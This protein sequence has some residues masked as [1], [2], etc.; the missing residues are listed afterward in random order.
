MPS[1]AGTAGAIAYV[2]L[3][4]R[5]DNVG[6][7][8]YL[9]ESLG[10]EL[11]M[12]EADAYRTR[13][14][15]QPR[16][17][18]GTPYGDRAALL[19]W[20]LEQERSGCDRY[21][22]SLDQLLSGGL[23]N[24]RSMARS[25]PIALPD[26]RVLTEAEA[27]ETLL[28]ALLADGNN[29]VW[30]LDSVMRLA[31]TVGYDH[32]DLAGYNALRA[33]GAEARPTLAGA[34]L[35]A[36]NVEAAYRFGAERNEAL[37]PQAFSLTER[38]VEEYLAARSR[39]LELSA[40]VLSR[41]CDDEEGT[42]RFRVLIGIDDSS[43]EE[44]IQ[45]NEIAYLST[46]LRE[47]DAILSGVD[48]LAFKAVARLYLDET[49]WG[50]AHVGV[51]Y[52]GGMED[53]PACEYDSKPL[54]E[55]V[56]E[57]FAFFDLTRDELTPEFSVLV[58]TQPADAGRRA[59]YIGALTDALNA[60]R[61]AHVPTVLIDASNGKFDASLYETLTKKTELGYLLAYAGFLDMAI[62]TGT[63]ISHGAARYAFLQN[64]GATAETEAAFAKTL[65]D[66][67]IKDF[68]Y[69]HAVRDQVIARVREQQGNPDNFW[70]PR[71]DTEALRGFLTERM[72]AA[73]GDVVKNL[74]KS[75]M[76]A[77]LT[78]Y[79]ERTWG[80]LTAGGFTFPWDRAFEIDME[81]GTG[82]WKKR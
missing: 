21:V 69:K 29:R 10:Y 42:E 11:K 67:V 37:A 8:K 24:S 63:A 73:I 65:A 41:L 74:E 52:V 66:S 68:C 14:R 15:G 46:M 7:V 25:E 55:I 22:L 78:P 62:V 18:S 59:E 30:L 47:G 26:G 54:R 2:P 58:L 5:P 34:E 44:S 48:D 32:W 28:T 23:V 79:E 82:A 76:I 16:N 56:D 17:D 61:R 3:D 77:S 1:G 27:A 20:V 80:A 60:A 4:D 51:T 9:A 36:E 81:L 38:E 75:G 49:G 13:L 64:G 31:P 71:L 45:K 19:T 57:H 6:R 43:V 72:D 33:Y 12:P 50:G 53:R 35:T 39:K 40:K 70:E